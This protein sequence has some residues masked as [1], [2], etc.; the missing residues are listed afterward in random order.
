MEILQVD[1][2]LNEMLVVQDFC[3]II[4]VVEAA[5]AQVQSVELQP[6]PEVQEVVELEAQVAQVPAYGPEIQH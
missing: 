3:M 5:V 2:C 4:L 6:V 1:L